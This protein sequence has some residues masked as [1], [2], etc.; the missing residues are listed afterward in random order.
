MSHLALVALAVCVGTLYELVLS[1]FVHLPPELGAFFGELG[2]FD[3]LALCTVHGSPL[4]HEECVWAH[5]PLG[6]VRVLELLGRHC[7]FKV[8][9]ELVSREREALH[10]ARDGED[11]SEFKF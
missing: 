3:I 9:R 5:S 4:L 6:L 2:E 8:V 10:L 1:L 11:R 7:R